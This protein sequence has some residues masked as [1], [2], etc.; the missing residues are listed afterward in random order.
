MQRRHGGTETCP[1]RGAYLVRSKVLGGIT[2]IAPINIVYFDALDREI[3]RD[4]QGFDERTIRV[5][6]QYD[7]LGRLEKQSR[8]YFVGDTPPWTTFTYD[9]LGRVLTRTDPDD[10]PNG[11]VT[12]QVFQGLVTVVTND[13]GT[14][15]LN[16]TVTTT[17][18]SQGQVVSVKTRPAIPPPTS[19]TRSATRSR[20]PIRSTTRSSIPT[21][22]GAGRS[23]A[24]IPI[25]NWTSRMTRSTS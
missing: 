16:Q 1:D 11:T 20:Q 19:T 21:T 24:A 15:R 10:T 8:P 9:A 25:S 22:P 2:Q 17:K 7:S 12:Q 23:P 18:N 14:N 4:T 6:K 5:S 3:G 13:A